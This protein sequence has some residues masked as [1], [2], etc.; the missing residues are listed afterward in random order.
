M[1]D[2]KDKLDLMIRDSWKMFKKSLKAD[3]EKGCP[4]EETIASYV[5]GLLNQKETKNV[6]QHLLICNDCLEQVKIISQTMEI[7]EEVLQEVPH[8]IINRILE[9]VND[10]KHLFDVILKFTKETIELI[11]NPG[12]LGVDLSFSPAA[13]RGKKQA[14]S[15]N[16]IIL[17]KSFKNISFSIE[18]ENI[19]IGLGEM[20]IKILDKGPHFEK[21]LRVSL[22][23]PKR[24][25]ASHIFEDENIVFKNISSGKY[26]VKF[27]HKKREIGEISFN[28][29]GIMVY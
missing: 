2:K 24:E 6:E 9:L 25:L 7:K 28:I 1:N 18:I 26:K 15:P 27:M 17:T 12:N 29:I 5:E 4:D 22:F 10:K 21:D 13:I 14:S 19:G 20:K 3:K 8:R 23:D 11:K 16:I